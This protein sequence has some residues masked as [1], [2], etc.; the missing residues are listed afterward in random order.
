MNGYVNI[1]IGGKDR[2]FK[3]GLYV[4]SEVINELD[5]NVI[6]IDSSLEK[7]PIKGVALLMF[8]A[9]SYNCLR[10]NEACD[11]TVMDVYDW[12]DNEPNGLQSEAVQK[13]ITAF[14][15]SMSRDVPKDKEP[16]KKKND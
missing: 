14:Y 11:F 16:G 12:I 13:F 6:D 8:H 15:E 7:N 2:G 10:A 4:L 5:I 1:N 9:G 3:L